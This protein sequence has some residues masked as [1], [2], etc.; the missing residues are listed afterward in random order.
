MWIGY[1]GTIFLRKAEEQQWA[2]LALYFQTMH[3][4]FGSGK[5]IVVLVDPEKIISRGSARFCITNN[6]RLAEFIVS[7][8]PSRFAEFECASQLLQSLH[9]FDA[10]RFSSENK[11]SSC[12]IVRAI[13]Y[14]RGIDVEM[15]WHWKVRSNLHHENRRSFSRGAIITPEQGQITVCSRAIVGSP[16]SLVSLAD[17]E[18][19]QFPST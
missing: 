19:W 14:A 18:T 10:A 7:Q 13:D 6:L 5:L 11:E 2:A 9:Y 8:I 17:N 1:V 15:M 4:P 12:Q 3:S 16:I